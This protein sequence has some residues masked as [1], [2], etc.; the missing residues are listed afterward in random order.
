MGTCFFITS[1]YLCI[2]ITAMMMRLMMVMMMMINIF[3]PRGKRDQ[4][5]NVKD[6]D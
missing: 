6:F 1:I 4:N 3:W 2:I 5:K